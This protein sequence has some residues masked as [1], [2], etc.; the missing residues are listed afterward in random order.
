MHSIVYKQR[1][2]TYVPVPIFLCFF[3][4]RPLIVINNQALRLP[5]ILTSGYQ[6]RM[7]VAVSLGKYIIK[8]LPKLSKEPCKVK[9][10]PRNYHKNI[11]TAV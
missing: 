11:G 7:H 3:M 2:H 4:L 5:W 9:S 6:F 10:T 8:S 1:A